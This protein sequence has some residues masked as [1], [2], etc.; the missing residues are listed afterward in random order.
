MY[1]NEK[2]DRWKTIQ[3]QFPEKKQCH[4]YLNIIDTTNLSMNIILELIFLCF[5]AEVILVIN[6]KF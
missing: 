1:I 4:F 3:K 2:A 6:V 5:L